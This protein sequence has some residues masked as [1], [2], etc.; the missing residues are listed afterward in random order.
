MF[1]LRGLPYDGSVKRPG[2]V[3]HLTNDIVYARLAPGVLRE[4]RDRNPAIDGRRKHRHFQ[5]LTQDIGHPKLQEHLVKVTTL[6]QVSD[7]W[8]GF[9]SLL[10]RGFQKYSK[11]PL[12]RD[13][14]DEE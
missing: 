4:L 12:F 6:M 2:Y 11:L 7:D 10:D 13:I 9:K 3:G 14:Q 1:R 5:W 8:N